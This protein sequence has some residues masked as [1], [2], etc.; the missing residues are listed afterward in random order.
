[1]PPFRAAGG[2]EVSNNTVSIIVYGV[3][4][5]LSFGAATTGCVQPDKPVLSAFLSI[6]GLCL[7]MLFS[8]LFF[9][10]WGVTK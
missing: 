3:L 9:R 4:S 7:G 8:A 6:A 1:M 10:A 5:S 2:N